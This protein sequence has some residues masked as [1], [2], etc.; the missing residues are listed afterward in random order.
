MRLRDLECFVRVCETGSLN[1]AAT[2]L[3]IAQPALGLLVRKLEHDFGVDLF[4]RH[5]RGVS[6]TVQGEEVKAWANEVLAGHWRMRE[7]LRWS[8]LLPEHLRM[9]LSP[10]AAALLAVGMPAATRHWMPGV[11]VDL[12]EG[13]SHILVDSIAC[14][15]LDLALTFETPQSAL[16]YSEPVL[17]QALYLIGRAGMFAH[18]ETIPFGSAL[19]RD[20]VIGALPA[21]VRYVVEREARKIGADVHIVHE[22]ESLAVLKSFVLE[23]SYAIL[24][25]GSV[26]EDVAA[27]RL[28]AARIVEPDIT[29]TLSLVRRNEAAASGKGMIDAPLLECIRSTLPASLPEGITIH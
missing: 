19:R 10:S 28:S 22:V 7:R 13:A 25:Y 9:G 2:V 27:G 3:N 24:P 6:P 4:V 21:S 5:A 18:G 17:H 26:G 8:K 12:M 16:L 14:S 11:S 20:L 1:R 23:G 29:R 15:T